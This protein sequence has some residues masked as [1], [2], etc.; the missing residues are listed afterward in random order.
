M[1]ERNTNKLICDSDTFDITTMDLLYMQF[2]QH[3]QPLEIVR[4][5]IK[6]PPYSDSRL[7]VLH[8]TIDVWNDN[9]FQDNSPLPLAGSI[10]QTSEQERPRPSV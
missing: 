1:E 2:R 5:A 3:I 7:S 10:H 8:V 6:P 4:R 9:C